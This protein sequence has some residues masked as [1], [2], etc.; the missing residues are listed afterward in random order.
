MSLR[1]SFL[2]NNLKDFKNANSFWIN[3]E[4]KFEKCKEECN[5][6]PLRPAKCNLNF[7]EIELTRKLDF[8][9]QIF[10]YNT[11]FILS[12]H[13][14]TKKFFSR[15]ITQHAQRDLNKIENTFYGTFMGWKSMHQG[16]RIYF[17]WNPGLMAIEKAS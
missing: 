10:H 16:F 8:L 4:K 17:V 7:S 1:D 2:Y 13:T 6:L 3:K 11:L 5:S 14:S 9:S 15:Y 12:N